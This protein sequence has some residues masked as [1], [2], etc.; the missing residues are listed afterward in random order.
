ML[1]VGD[2]HDPG[3]G[4]GEGLQDGS[5]SL[6][7]NF[8]LLISKLKLGHSSPHPVLAVKILAKNSTQGYRK[9]GQPHHLDD[10]PWEI[11]SATRAAEAHR[12]SEIAKSQLRITGEVS[13]ST[14]FA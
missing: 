4:A 9:S 11:A 1:T 10:A 12:K 6:D 13:R 3:N 5:F 7:Q 2:H 8:S 14:E